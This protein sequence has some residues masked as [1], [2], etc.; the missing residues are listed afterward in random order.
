MRERGV[1]V[2]TDGPVHNVITIRG[3]MPLTLADADRIVE[4]LDLLLSE[5]S[6]QF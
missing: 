5:L 1:P 6:A 4:T 3:P 2:G